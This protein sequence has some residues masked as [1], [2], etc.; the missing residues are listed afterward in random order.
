[1]TPTPTYDRGYDDHAA[2][3]DVPGKPN[4]TSAP[5]ISALLRRHD[6]LPIATHNRQREG[7]RVQRGATRGAVRVVA[8]YDSPSEAER[9]ADEL[10]ELLTTAGFTI[11][12]AG[13]AMQ[14]T[15]PPYEPDAVTR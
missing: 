13:A 11:V 9:V 15:N 2:M 5:A 8:D 1:M 12:R 6:F 14:V 7:V 10:A 4:P 3:E